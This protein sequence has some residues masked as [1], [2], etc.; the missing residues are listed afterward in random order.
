M[1]IIV[2][3]CTHMHKHRKLEINKED[4]VIDLTKGISS[5]WSYYQLCLAT[6]QE[7]F[8]VTDGFREVVNA[9]N[10]GT[11]SIAIG[12]PK[13]VGKSLAL[14]AIAELS[15]NKWPCLLWSTVEYLDE[16]CLYVK[17]VYKQYSK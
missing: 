13:G 11:K 5:E 1:F 3:P 15:R 12:G 4:P 9:L 7:K 14:A 6:V 17:E 8:L 16:Y 2:F 10:S